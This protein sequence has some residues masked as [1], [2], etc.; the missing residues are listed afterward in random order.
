MKLF[1]FCHINQLSTIFFILFVFQF[2]ILILV[3]QV[4]QI[5]YVLLIDFSSIGISYSIGS[6]QCFLLIYVSIKAIGHGL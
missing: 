6:I 2:D 3:S 1:T 4:T 5:P